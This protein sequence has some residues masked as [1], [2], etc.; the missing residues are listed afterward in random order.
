MKRKEEVSKHVVHS[1]SARARLSR[2]FSLG[3][4]QLA[5]VI[6]S[7]C[8]CMQLDYQEFPHAALHA[9]K[10]GM[11]GFTSMCLAYSTSSHPREIIIHYL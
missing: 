7:E 1:A 2:G 4:P 6:G 5:S 3:K 10:V 11:S 9:T 8:V